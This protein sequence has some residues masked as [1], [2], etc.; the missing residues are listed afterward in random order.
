M[1]NALL[2]KNNGLVF[3]DDA[4]LT[5]DEETPSECCCECCDM[6]CLCLDL[7]GGIVC[8]VALLLDDTPNIGLGCDQSWSAT[9]V[10]SCEGEFTYSFVLCCTDG[11]YSLLITIECSPS[12]QNDLIKPLETVLDCDSEFFTIFGDYI[13]V[14]PCVDTPV[15]ITITKGACCCCPDPP[16][17]ICLTLTP[18]TELYLPCAG[19]GETITLALVR[20]DTDI[21]EDCSQQ[22]VLEAGNYCN[23]PPECADLEVYLRC[24]NGMYTLTIIACQDTTPVEY[25]IP[26]TLVDCDDFTFT[27]SYYFIDGCADGAGYD[28]AVSGGAC[29]CCCPCEESETELTIAFTGDA[30]CTCWDSEEA[31]LTKYCDGGFFTRVQTVVPE[32]QTNGPALPCNSDPSLEYAINGNNCV[33]GEY[34]VTFSLYSNGSNVCGDEATTSNGQLTLVSCDPFH[35]TGYFL[36]EA[37]IEGGCTNLCE[38]DPA[39]GPWRID[40]EITE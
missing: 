3:V 6:P 40:F 20:D 12:S 38:A 4:L 22:W 24:C 18:T 26:L 7:T 8:N 27:T 29:A 15:F 11:I 9:G 23:Y 39:T 16:D 28:I 14:G 25:T 10:E 31:L 34:S 36:F 37:P 2:V 13:P 19:E 5:V 21:P 30:N 33:D 35:M 32:G 17:D 1:A